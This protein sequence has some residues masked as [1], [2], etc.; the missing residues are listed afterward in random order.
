MKIGVLLS[1]CGV[2][3]GSEIHETVFTLL[4]IAEAGHEAVCIGINKD[5]HH[6][7]NH[8]TGEEQKD[9]RNMMVEA[10]RIA[11]GEITDIKDI[12]PADLDV[13]IIPGGAGSAKNLTD[14]AF[15]GPEGTILPEVKLLIVNMLNV[16]K[17]IV[18]LCVSPVVVAK[19]LQG[20]D[21]KS[22]MTIG[23]DQAESPYD[24]KG[25]VEGLTKAG[26]ST[27]MKLADEINIDRVNKIVTAP[28]YMMKSDLITLRNNIANAV[29]AG[30]E[31]V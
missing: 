13:L 12:S 20:S 27:T 24:I 6:V 15:N 19:A 14:W 4:A 29:N 2:N 3:D 7:I 30:I 5:Q 23:S 28:C 25:F 22:F 21:I 18:A 17:P 31:L 16:G 11:R 1:G 9:T 10:A 8:L 26:V